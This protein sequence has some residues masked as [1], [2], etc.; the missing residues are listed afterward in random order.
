MKK[1]ALFLGL[2]TALVASCSIEEKEFN[3]PV[4]D[5]IVYY[6]SFEQDGEDT[7]VF[8]NEDLLLR[9]TADDRISIFGKNTHN[10]QYRFTGATGDNAGEFAK[11]EGADYVVGN[12]IP[13]T[14]AVIPYDASTRISES[15]AITVTLPAEQAYAEHSFGP[16]ANTMVSV[17]EDNV[18]QFSTV[19]GYLKLRLWGEGVEV[20]SIS[21]KGK[22]GEKLAGKATVTMPLG[23]T[24]S[25]ALDGAATDEIVLVCETPVALGAT[26]AEAVDFWLV[27]PPVKFTQ[28]FTV[29]VK[30]KR[31]RVFEK[32]TSKVVEIERN[33]LSKM[34]A[35]EVVPVMGEPTDLSAAETAN[36]Y[37]I[38]G[39]G[40]Y[41]FD[42][43]VIGNGDKGILEPEYFHTTTAQIAPASVALLWQ[44]P[45]FIEDILLQDGKVVFW[46]DAVEGNAV[47][48]VKDAGGKILWSW[49][50]WSTDPPRGKQLTAATHTIMDRDLGATATD[51][52]DEASHGLF[53]QWGR[54]DPL[55]EAHVEA[56]DM[57]EP[58][59]IETLIE[60]P[61]VAPYSAGSSQWVVT[62]RLLNYGLWG[63]PNGPVSTAARKTI[64]DPCPAGYTIPADDTW[65]EYGLPSN[66]E[67]RYY[68]LYDPSIVLSCTTGGIAATTDAGSLLYPIVTPL[69]EDGPTSETMRWRNS[70]YGGWCPSADFSIDG[71]NATV[72]PAMSSWPSRPLPVRCI[73]EETY[74]ILPPVV[75]TLEA[76]DIRITDM[77]LRGTV[78][79]NG[80][81]T[82]TVVGFLW[83]YAPDA[84]TNRFEASYSISGAFSASLDQLTAFSTVYYKAF[85]ENAAGTG[86]GDVLS[87]QLPTVSD[88]V[89]GQIDALSRLMTRQYMNAQGLNGEGAIR[90]WYGDLTGVT[91]STS[92]TA[93]AH[94][95]NLNDL[96]D[97][98]IV[99]DRFPLVYYY[100][101]INRAN[102]LLDNV[103]PLADA[104]D[105]YADYYK[106]QILGYRAYAYTMLVQL[107]AKSWDLSGNGQSSAVPLRISA[108]EDVT[109]P[110]T[111]AQVYARIYQDLDA[112][113]G[114]M[115]NYSVPRSDV[116]VIDLNVLYAIYAKAALNRKDYAKARQYAALAREGHP[117]MSNEEYGQGFNSS[118]NEWIWGAH[119]DNRTGAINLYFYSYFAYVGS[120]TSSSVGRNNPLSI[121]NWLF[122]RIPDTDIRK[123][124]WLDPTGYTYNATNGRANSDLQNYARSTFGDYLY[125]TGTI[126]AWMQFKFRNLDQ[127]GIGQMNFIRAAEMYLVEAEADWFLGNE[128]DAKDLLVALNKTSGRDPAYA[129]AKSGADLLD[130]IK[131]YRRI[132]LWGEGFDWYDLKRWGEPVVRTSFAD[133]GNFMS[134]FAGTWAAADKN[135]FVWV[136]PTDYETYVREG[137]EN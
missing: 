14:V 20:A 113:I 79:S 1:L 8:V 54:K 108:D 22:A 92:R 32:S 130:E 47:I 12:A 3:R 16:G 49:H 28:G 36:C 98:D 81:S 89:I 131:F 86:Y 43:T 46:A 106:A 53:Y 23:G 27:V 11:V 91:M 136:F 26:E 63:N 33:M 87:A 121:A 128:S 118:N 104:S 72:N 102:A 117:L 116:N 135:D 7:R 35:F 37:I 137:M 57:T 70:W 97:P 105:L 133:G 115:Q 18:L 84:L 5:D 64:Y 80:N 51:P 124:L 10:Q 50:I 68:S 82:L 41:S 38:P 2:A 110:A 69:F 73:R 59:T 78:R 125:S 112:A 42:A 39:K 94:L 119:P 66:T 44:E 127:P 77:T 65:Y 71:D 74:S 88:Y 19:G 76:T 9:W 15:E 107:Y 123:G 56:T 30:D 13:H 120:N 100:G 45:V 99:Y 55:H 25:V 93:W 132:E 6:A 111:L 129:C 114:L 103:L 83:G 29:T 95:Y 58:P 101:I 109:A 62:R 52:A 67:H 90:H 4:Q 85:A 96:T 126:Y 40:W 24:P 17:S 60:N 134:A 122:E 34:A 48:A 31:D 75:N 21:L 61:T